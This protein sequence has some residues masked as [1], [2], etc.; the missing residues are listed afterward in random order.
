[1]KIILHSTRVAVLGLFA[2]GGAMPAA[3]ADEAALTFTFENDVLTGSDNNYTNGFGLSYVSGELDS[4]GEDSFVRKWSDFWS[5]LPFVEDE[6]YTTYASWTVAQEMH[7]P[8]DI[9]DPNPPLDDQPYAGVLYVDSILYARKDRWAHAWQLK[10]GVVGPASHADDLQK[11]IHDL[12]GGDE[13]MGWDTQLPD[14]PI[15]NV[16]YTGRI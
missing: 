8:D 16:G 4:Y 15:I 11:D 1:M 10:L 6:G 13:P 7:T 14:E 12:M 3:A 9:T 5:F 2:L